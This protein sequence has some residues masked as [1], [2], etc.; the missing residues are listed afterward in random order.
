MSLRAKHIQ[1]VKAFGEDAIGRAVGGLYYREGLD[2]LTDDALE[3]LAKRLKSDDRAAR[4][5]AEEDRARALP[6]VEWSNS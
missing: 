1:I 6:A 3:A 4:R 2:I 5:R